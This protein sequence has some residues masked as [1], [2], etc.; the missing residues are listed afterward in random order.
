MNERRLRRTST[1]QHAVE[2]FLDTVCQAEAIEA[3][4]LTDAE[5][6]LIAGAGKGDV[7][8]LGALGATARR[9]TMKWERQTLH[10]RK[11]M[12]AGVACKLTSLGKAVKRR[13]VAAGLN[14]ILG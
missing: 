14:R 11:V 2:F 13:D 3:I 10:A 6:F 12:V 7:E 5:G 4:A 1:H 9:A 8:Q